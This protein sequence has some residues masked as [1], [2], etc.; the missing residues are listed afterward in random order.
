VSAQNQDT[1]SPGVGTT[2]LQTSTQLVIVDVV[3]QSKDGHP[4]HGL[5]KEMFRL[6]EGS[7]PQ[8]IRHF[9]EHSSTQQAAA[10]NP[11]MPKMP[12]GTFTDYSPVAPDATLNVL[13]LDSLNTPA[14]AQ[15]YVRNQLQ[16]YIK[17]ANPGTRIAIFG[18]A[19]QLVLLQG[20]TS[21][22]DTLKEAI[23][24]KL[25]PRYSS[26]L[27]DPSGSGV[28]HV[29]P[30]DI[31]GAGADQT[32]PAGAAP[33]V[34]EA[35]AN[36][37]QFE[38][39]TTA[40]QTQMRVQYTLDAFNA[41]G[42]YLAAFPGRKNL[43]WFSGSFP[44]NVLPDPALQNSFAV[45]NV[46][47]DAFHEMTNLLA[48]AQIAVY[49]VDAR[50][51]AAPP[52]YSAS[53]SGR[54]YG[55]NPQ[56]IQSQLSQ[57]TTSQ[58]SE[59]T[60]MDTLAESTG[61]RAF[62][63]TNALSDAVSK[64]VDAGANYYTLTYSPTDHNQDGG[65]RK[66]T[67]EYT[68]AS[69]GANLHLSYR[70]GYYAN[71][72]RRKQGSGQSTAT[73]SG[74]T[75]GPAALAVAYQRAAMSRG[76]PAPQEILFTA[77]VLPAAATTEAAPVQS[78]RLSAGVSP[79]GPFRRYDIDC[80][81]LPKDATLTL[82]PDGR[83]QGTINFMVY[84]FD[85]PGDLLNAESTSLSLNLNSK[86]YAT[87]LHNALQMHLE[88]SVPAKGENFLRIGVNDVPS[89]RFGVVEIPVAAVSNLAPPVYQGAPKTAPPS[90]T[91][92]N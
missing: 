44:L 47:Q 58:A 21:D 57:F 78:N 3:V 55:T 35:A 7:V 24:H 15:S 36:F 38:A 18:L 68:G 30:S 83:R 33:L 13:L 2:I 51:L 66:I 70:H 69:A 9:E 86:D 73:V 23:K 8:Q 6:M 28:D 31:T 20:F 53:S 74:D 91:P 77:R 64:A 45:A 1:P 26:L 79:K 48:K 12:A 10:P 43:I 54:R 62:Y 32:S 52:V 46:N 49:P 90:T 22:P 29:T 92:Q 84:V 71:D 61:G 19:N 65:Y 56:A 67:V 11:E 14:T 87:F 37:Q 75:G 50:G 4:V 76:A 41:L 85:G 60:T 5:K 34:V 63:N 81:V 59:H 88:V 25:I 27:D 89:N 40:M 42:R 39:E 17:H 80:V 72:S 82:Q 16:E